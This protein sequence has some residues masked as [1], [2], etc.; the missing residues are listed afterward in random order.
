MFTE[1]W[2]N[3]QHHQQLSLNDVAQQNKTGISKEER[4]EFITDLWRTSDC[5]KAFVSALEDN[6]Y[7]LAQGR[8]P[9]ILVDVFG[10]QNALTRMID[11]KDVRQADVIEFLK[12]DFIF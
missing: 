6:G 8:R 10:G 12:K 7:I 9:Y 3:W 11:D 4:R 2:D 1:M 5:P